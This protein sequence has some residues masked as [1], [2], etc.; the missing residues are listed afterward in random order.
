MFHSPP[1]LLPLPLLITTS[2]H[3]AKNALTIPLRTL[4]KIRIL[5]IA[6]V[7]CLAPPRAIRLRQTLQPHLLVELISLLGA[8]GFI[9]A[10][11]AVCV[12]LTNSHV[13]EVLCTEG[14]GHGSGSGRAFIN[15]RGAVWVVVFFGFEQRDGAAGVEGGDVGF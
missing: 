7:R 11:A 6:K 10:G 4:P 13:D 2:T 1:H 3:Q 5:H 8:A 14:S 9:G 12:F 15:I